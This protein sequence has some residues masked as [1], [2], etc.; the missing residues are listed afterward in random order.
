MWE[1]FENEN[2]YEDSLV[3]FPLLTPLIKINQV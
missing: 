2:Y 1:P 3:M